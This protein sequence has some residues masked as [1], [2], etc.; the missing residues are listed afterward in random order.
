[1]KKFLIKDNVQMVVNIVLCVWIIVGMLIIFIV[2]PSTWETA[3]IY[4]LSALISIMLFLIYNVW[5]SA[6]LNKES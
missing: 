6:E 4:P 3:I 5:V 2:P 1:M